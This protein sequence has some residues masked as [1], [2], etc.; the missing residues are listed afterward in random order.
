M[1][2]TVICVYAVVKPGR[3]FSSIL[4]AAKVPG[5]HGMFVPCWVARSVSC[6]PCCCDL[7]AGEVLYLDT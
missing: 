6:L 1:G 3:P 4:Y 2:A 7:P 5:R